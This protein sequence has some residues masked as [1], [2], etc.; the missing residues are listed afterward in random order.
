MKIQEAHPGAPQFKLFVVLN[1]ARRLILP[2]ASR[3]SAVR[4]S[5]N[6]STPAVVPPRSFP[7]LV[8]TLIASFVGEGPLSPPGS[9]LFP[10]PR[11]ATTDK[12]PSF[13]LLFLSPLSSRGVFPDPRAAPLFPTRLLL[14]KTCSGNHPLMLT[15]LLFPW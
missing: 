11:P 12:P 4:D 1:N 2:S 3:S 10:V 14:V 15:P 9:H 8:P 13:S 6:L 5:R 7:H